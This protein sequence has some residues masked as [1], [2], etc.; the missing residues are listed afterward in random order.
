MKL[1]SLMSDGMVLQR[2]ASVP[3]WG[4]AQPGQSVEVR[5]VN[6]V[7]KTAAD[8]EGEWHISLDPMEAGGPYELVVQAEGEPEVVIRDVMIGEVWV[9]GGQ[10]N[11]QLPVRRTLDLF[12]DEIARANFPDIRQF[13]V[14]QRYDFHGPRYDLSD[15]AWKKAVQDDVL[16]FSAAGFFFAQA[17]YKSYG[18]P[19]GLVQTAIGG[20]PVEA[21]MSEPTL[22]SFGNYDETL[23]RCKDDDYV[24]R[25]IR[26]D[27]ERSHHWHE[28]LNASDRGLL[29]KWYELKSLDTS[30][31]SEAQLPSLWYGTELAAHRGS[32]WF[33]RE[34]DVPE[35]IAM[36][37][38]LLKLG[39]IVDAD[40]TYVNGVLVGSTSY[41][42]PPRRYP[43]PA[44]VLRPGKNV[45]SVRV[46]STHNTGGFIPEMPYQLVLGDQQI[47]LTGAWQY[48]IGATTDSL[49]PHTFFHYMPS[50]LY[51]GM[52]VPISR[53]RMRGVLWYQG[54]SNT[55]KPRGYHRLF[56]AMMRDWRELWGFGSFPFLF[57]QLA[58]FDG[59]EEPQLDHTVSNK[60]AQLRNE[61]RLALQAENTGMAV[62]ID[63]GEH[64]DL[65]PQDKKTLGERLALLARKLAYGE[66]LVHSG[67]LYAGMDMLGHAIRLYFDHVGSGLVAKGDE[68]LHGFEICAAD[69][70]FVPARAELAGDTVVV[71]SDQVP[72]PRH[73]RYAWADNPASANLYNKEG[74]PA[75]PFTTES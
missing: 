41:K 10:S 15:G 37:E 72:A 19:I 47:D 46:I 33:R 30:E 17:L 68:E 9:L 36:G 22:R 74:L 59:E 5:I 49:A 1:S 73:V 70:R 38:A 67:P 4:S 71:S 61:Q 60:W 11:M 53:Y 16:D 62:T 75:S 44:G 25:T 8:H 13:T 64:N 24:M 57:T 54:E 35:S 65:H 14:P 40:D 2:H 32:V 21:W 39:T 26:E 42:Y 51:N 28:A 66:E 43:I 6:R 69:G 7:Y 31:W 29:E 27:E 52:I 58:N 55:E 20:T 63:I 34:I 50:G 45:I 3:I 48:R 56:Q 18:V 23:A 12:A